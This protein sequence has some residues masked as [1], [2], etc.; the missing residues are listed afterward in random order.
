VEENPGKG[1]AFEINKISNK[2]KKKLSEDEFLNARK[3]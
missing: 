3:K 1:I 2:I